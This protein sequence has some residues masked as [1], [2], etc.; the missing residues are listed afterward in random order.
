M[1][2]KLSKKI[3]R[4]ISLCRIKASLPKLKLK[5]VE[6]HKFPMSRLIKSTLMDIIEVMNLKNEKLDSNPRGNNMRL[7]KQSVNGKKDQKR[8]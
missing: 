5:L 6:I 2:K 8:F 3:K 7:L 4:L 1:N